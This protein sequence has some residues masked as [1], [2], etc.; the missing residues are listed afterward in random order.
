MNELL[1]IAWLLLP[2]SALLIQYYLI[3][4]RQ[5]LLWILPLLSLAVTFFIGLAAVL[6]AFFLIIFTKVLMAEDPHQS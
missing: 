5:N 3:Q 2:A 6:N 1:V 4:K